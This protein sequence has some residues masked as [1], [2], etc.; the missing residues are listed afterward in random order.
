LS[1]RRRRAER[2]AVRAAASSSAG[3]AVAAPAS[4]GL[5]AR[6]FAPVD[7]A[8]LVCF[9]VAF[10]AAMIVEVV[11]YFD[12]GWIG[13]Y[14]VKPAFHFTYYGFAW[15]KPWPGAGMYVHFASWASR[16]SA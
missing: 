4:P 6:A 2:D 8:S 15:V 13:S 7:N 9:R 12:H 16:P 3:V 1:K 10:G 5:L 14:Y 11:R